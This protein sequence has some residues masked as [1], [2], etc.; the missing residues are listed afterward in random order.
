MGPARC[1]EYGRYVGQRYRHYDNIVWLMGGDRNPGP[2]LDHVDSVVAGIKEHDDRHLFTAH[3][4]PEHSPTVEYAESG[5][6]DVNATYTYEIVHRK[7]LADYNRTPAMPFFLIESTY[8]GEHNASAVQIRR[9]AYWAILCGA[10]GQFLGNLPVWGFYGPNAPMEGTF[11]LDNEG[12]NANSVCAGWQA[13]LD[14]AGACDMAHLKALFTS[15]AWYDLVPDQK[16]AVV[17]KGLGEFTGLDYLA[18]ARTVDGST[19]IAYMPTPRSVTV[20]MSSLSGQ[21][22]RGWWFDPRSGKSVP[23]GEFV[24]R[25]CAVLTPPGEGDWILV[26]DD[27]AKNLPTPGYG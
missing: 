16:H 24:T 20:D 22:A 17:T 15:R 11:F 26:L 4:R 8:E 18:A 23:A 19:V 25:G 14:D 1:R 27:A 21:A 7:L 2:A 5:W 6:L 13:A 9:Q 10:M 3:T 12:R